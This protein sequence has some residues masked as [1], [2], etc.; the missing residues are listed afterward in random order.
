MTVQN[1]N[2]MRRTHSEYVENIRAVKGD[3]YVAFVQAAT[4][5][6]AASDC[7]HYSLTTG[8][9]QEEAL[10]LFGDL[11][12]RLLQFSANEAGMP[13]EQAKDAMEDVRVMMDAVS[14]AADSPV[15]TLQ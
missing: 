10:M 1:L 14:S 8:A 15:I 4:Q 5:I 12:A 2:A 6:M 3:A 13:H 9:K 7:V 11:V